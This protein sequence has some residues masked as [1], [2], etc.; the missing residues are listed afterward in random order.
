MFVFSIAILFVIEIVVLFV[1]LS[2]C[3]KQEPPRSSTPPRPLFKGQ[4]NH[5]SLLI[6]SSFLTNIPAYSFLILDQCPHQK[7]KTKS[8]CQL[9]HLSQNYSFSRCIYAYIYAYK[10]L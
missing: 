2:I 4:L 10:H 7:T 1:K 5:L 3:G 9:T 6:L 8:T